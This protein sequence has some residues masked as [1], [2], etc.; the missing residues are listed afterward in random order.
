MRY[1]GAHAVRI[2]YYKDYADGSAVAFRS[3][4]NSTLTVAQNL[5]WNLPNQQGESFKFLITTSADGASGSYGQSM[6][7][8]GIRLVA[9]A[10]RG[11]FNKFMGILTKG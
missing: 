7:F 1:L 10:K 3:F 4:A 8:N 11:S 2:D 6:V 9:L 5:V